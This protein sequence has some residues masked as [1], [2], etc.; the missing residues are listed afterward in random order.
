M[1]Q[2][3]KLTT[4]TLGCGLIRIGRVWGVD[5][6][7]VP[8]DPDVRKFL[9]G[10]FQFGIRFFDTA[11]SYGLSEKRLA[12][13]LKSL[14]SEQLKEVTIAT[15]FG[16]YWD[17]E[18]QEPFVDHT[19]E[20][21]KSSLDESLSTLGKIE[22]LQLHKASTSLLESTDVDRAFSYAL[23]AGVS[24]LGVSVSDIETGIKACSDE[25][26]THIQLPF[27][28]ERMELL[29]VI[30]KAKNN[31]K[32]VLFNRPFAMG[33]ITQ[34]SSMIAAYKRIASLECPGVIL[35]GTASLEHLKQN[36]TYF[37]SAVYGEK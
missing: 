37:E 5:N 35:T 11:P 4:L 10:A 12:A 2:Q 20:K 22:L 18:K 14:T 17:A 7:Q 28:Q 31:D 25:R 32:K 27:N 13:F 8:S 21:L 9:E 33:A 15:K 23:K 30:E 1:T 26:L 6:K 34:P 19:F 24:L 29:P 36:I 16:E 3:N